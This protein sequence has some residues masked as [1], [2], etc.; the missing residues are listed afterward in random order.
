MD[1]L[2]EIPLIRHVALGQGLGH[3]VVKCLFHK[4]NVPLPQK[5]LPRFLSFELSPNIEQSG[6][7]FFNVESSFIISFKTLEVKKK[8][9]KDGIMGLIFPQGDDL[10]ETSGQHLLK[11][12]FSTPQFATVPTTPYCHPNEL[13]ITHKNPHPGNK[14][15]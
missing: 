14:I 6:F 11:G 4:E 8:N 5:A 7:L 1:F 13:Y 2:L 9:Q 12:G 15:H 3:Y 10:P